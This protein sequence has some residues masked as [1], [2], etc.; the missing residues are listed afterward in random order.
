MRLI[1]KKP[2]VY[3]I[4]ALAIIV[5]AA[6]F[7]FFFNPEK[8]IF[9]PRCPMFALTGYYCPGCGSQRAIH[10]FLHLQFAD[11]VKYNA[12]IFP[13][14]LLILYHYIH[15]FLNRKFNL[16]LPN[17]LYMRY[18]PWVIF[19]IVVVFWIARNINVAPFTMLAPG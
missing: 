17:I 4:L 11:V 9:F 8:H 6:L 13:A 2:L 14:T 3:K 18:T 10:S 5:L 7:F 12:L 1:A 16:S 19:G 15:P